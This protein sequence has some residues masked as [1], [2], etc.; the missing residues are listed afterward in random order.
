MRVFALALR[1]EIVG[2]AGHA[3]GTHGFDARALDSFEHLAGCTRVRGKFAVNTF[4]MTGSGQR[5][6]VGPATND[7]DLSGRWHT[8]RLGQP[9][10]LA[11]DSRFLRAV[12]HLDVGVAGDGADRQSNGALQ[13]IAGSFPALRWLCHEPGLFPLTSSPGR[14]CKVSRS[15]LHSASSTFSRASILPCRILVRT[16]TNA[17]SAPAPAPITLFRVSDSDPNRALSAMAR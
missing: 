14:R 12:S 17:T 13:R 16:M 2:H 1:S 11:F 10:E 6:A 5:Q 8:R 9:Y 7:G 4:I 15:F 3:V